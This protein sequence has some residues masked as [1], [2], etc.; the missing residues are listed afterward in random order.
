VVFYYE[1]TLDG[2]VLLNDLSSYSSDFSQ[3]ELTRLQEAIFPKAIFPI[4]GTI[5]LACDSIFNQTNEHET[6]FQ[7]QFLVHSQNSFHLFGKMGTSLNK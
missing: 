5:L 3:M 2:G 6:E 7:N 1:G 4:K